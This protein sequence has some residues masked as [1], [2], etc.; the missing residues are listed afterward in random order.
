[1]EP[2]IGDQASTLLAARLKLAASKVQGQQ[3]STI[4]S[5][6][7]HTLFVSHTSR[8]DAYIT[9]AKDGTS[10]RQPGSIL[11]ICWEYF[12]DPFYHS[13]KTGGAEGYERIVG[14]AL[15]AAERVLIVW[16]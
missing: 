4:L 5:T 6:L 2:R 13:I 11:S 1:M 3:R 16:S 10:F 15:L 14:L 8:D 7:P 12:Y 9:G